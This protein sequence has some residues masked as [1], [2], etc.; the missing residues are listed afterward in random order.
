MRLFRKPSPTSLRWAH[1]CLILGLLA[2]ASRRGATPALGSFAESGGSSPTGQRAWAAAIPRDAVVQIVGEEAL[3]VC[4]KHLGDVE[5]G[6]CGTSLAQC[7]RLAVTKDGS[8]H[9]SIY[10]P[11][12]CA[13]IR[14]DPD[15]WLIGGP[16]VTGS[17]SPALLV[18]FDGVVVAP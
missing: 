12:A 5:G 8:G 4:V 9:I 14:P 3:T 16:S 10:G 1:L 18:G 6:T 7:T 17:K 2:C 11:P 13:Q 15:R